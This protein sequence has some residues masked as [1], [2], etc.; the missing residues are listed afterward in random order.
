MN[1]EEKLKIFADNLRKARE[2][3]G[4]SKPAAAEKLNIQPAQYYRYEGGRAEPGML[5]V[6]DIANKLQIPVATLLEGIEDN[7]PKNLYIVNKLRYYGIPA[8]L[9]EGDNEHIMVQINDFQPSKEP[10][11]FMQEVLAIADEITKTAMKK[12]VPAAYFKLLFDTISK[13]EIDK[14]LS[15]ALRKLKSPN[16]Q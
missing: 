10:I 1:K 16:K 4:L 9:I 2:N 15:E 7:I 14:Q 5:M 13:D 6:T 8:N 12:A 11:E 3:A